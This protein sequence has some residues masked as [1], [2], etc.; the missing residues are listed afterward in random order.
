VVIVVVI[1]YTVIRTPKHLTLFLFY[2]IIH[3]CNT[4]FI[5]FLTN[6]VKELA[7]PT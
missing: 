6:S 3:I 5:Y 4:I 1:T 2:N 7:V